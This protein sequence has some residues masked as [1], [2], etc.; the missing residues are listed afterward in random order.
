MGEGLDIGDYGMYFCKYIRSLVVFRRRWRI[1]GKGWSSVSSA[2][3][4]ILF[5]FTED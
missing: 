2:K 4:I 5:L 3:D 1:K